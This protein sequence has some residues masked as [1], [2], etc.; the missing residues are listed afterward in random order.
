MYQVYKFLGNK[1]ERERE[2]GQF[3]IPHH[4]V[5]DGLRIYN[6]KK[7]KIIYLL[8]CLCALNNISFRHTC[9]C[10]SSVPVTKPK[11]CT[12]LIE[13]PRTN[14]NLKLKL[15]ALIL[16]EANIGF[17]IFFFFF[18]HSHYNPFAR[19][20]SARMEKKSP[21][22]LDL[23]PRVSTHVTRSLS[24]TWCDLSNP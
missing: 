4:N 18:Y 14:S 23:F 12:R 8:A 7:K 5:R 20:T 1:R 19:K 22:P 11:A 15:S 24:C 17:A 13:I 21:C 9:K 6:S 16:N 3:Y 10:A 2:R